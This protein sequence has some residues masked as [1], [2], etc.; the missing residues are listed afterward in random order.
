MAITMPLI[1]EGYVLE[2]RDITQAYPQSS[3]ELKREIF[4]KLLKKLR[5]AYPPDT[6]IQV[7]RPFYGI[8]E[9]GV[10]WW[11]TYHKHHI[12]ELGMTISTYDSCLLITSKG[13]FGITGMQTDDTLILCTPEF[14]ATEEK[15]IQKAAFRA[16][17]KVQLA[18]SSPMEFNGAKLTLDSDQLNL[19]QKEQG[20]KLQFVNT[21]AEE[22][23]QQYFEQRARGAY[24]AFICQPEAAFDLSVAAQAYNPD[25]DDLTRLNKRL[26]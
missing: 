1:I 20:K 14:F 21:G 8:A 25:S 22:R 9:S 19:R 15:K 12:D 6:I 2:L 26:Q 24:L 3:S 5:N 13:P 17:P 11:F 18:E 4:A 10:H 16:K 7:I 23:D